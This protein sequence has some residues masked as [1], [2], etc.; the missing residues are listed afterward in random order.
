MYS[1]VFRSLICDSVTVNVQ[2]NS[3]GLDIKQAL[4]KIVNIPADDLIVQFPFVLP[5]EQFEKGVFCASTSIF[6]EMSDDF[7]FTEPILNH[8]TLLQSNSETYEIEF[9]SK[10]SGTE[11]SFNPLFRLF[12]KYLSLPEASHILNKYFE[13]NRSDIVISFWK[14]LLFD[15]PPPLSS[16]TSHNS[17]TTTQKNLFYYFE[18]P[19][20][21]A[22]T[23]LNTY[24]LIP[25]FPFSSPDLFHQSHSRVGFV[26]PCFEQIVQGVLKER[27]RIVSEF[28]TDRERGKRK[29]VSSSSSLPLILIEG[30]K[31]VGKSVF[32]FY[33]LKRLLL[34]CPDDV[35]ARERERSKQRE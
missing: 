9:A 21:Y 2:I 35:C 31:G 17:N 6:S 20:H 5:D 32:L 13:D 19:K 15:P 10:A 8:I 25:Q 12:P 29:E 27:E 7:T 3:K 4:S 11:P 28:F 22:A 16:R 26:R 1:L 34:S 24:S 23:A 33:L 14:H 30:R 18:H